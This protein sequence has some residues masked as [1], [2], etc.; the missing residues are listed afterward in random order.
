ML[1]LISPAGLTAA[2]DGG[3]WFGGQELDTVVVPNAQAG[4]Q[5]GSEEFI[6]RLC[7]ST[8]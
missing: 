7:P 3:G 4:I 1:R 6:T 5:G 8:S 2:G